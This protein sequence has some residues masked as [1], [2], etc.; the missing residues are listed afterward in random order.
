MTRILGDVQGE[1]VVVMLKAAGY[2]RSAV[3]GLLRKMQ[4][5]DLPLASRERDAEELQVMFDTLSFNKARTLL[6]YWDWA[7]SKTGPY[8]PVH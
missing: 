6:T 4:D 5:A 3:I 7:Q 1:A 8:A 2:P